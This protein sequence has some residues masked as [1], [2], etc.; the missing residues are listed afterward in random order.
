[1]S[2]VQYGKNRTDWILG[3]LYRVVFSDSLIIPI[4]GASLSLIVLAVHASWRWYMSA[5]RVKQTNGSSETRILDKNVIQNVGGPVI[6]AFR[7]A[8]LV[9][10]FAL[11]SMETW[12]IFFYWAETDWAMKTLEWGQ[13]GS[14][15]S[16]FVGWLYVT[17]GSCECRPT[18]RHWRCCRSYS[19]QRK[20]LSSF[21]IFVL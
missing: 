18:L 16:T 9:A 6:F 8:R 15:V 4:I 12:A 13:I 5:K 17:L 21:D 2:C 1:M 11:C 19:H 7:V 10:C 3:L 14:Y 20:P